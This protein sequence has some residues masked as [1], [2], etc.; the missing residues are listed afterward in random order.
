MNSC[1]DMQVS[2]LSMLSL[3]LF[4]SLSLSLSLSVSLSLSHILVF[5]RK[6]IHTFI[7]LSYFYHHQSNSLF[8]YLSLF[9]PFYQYDKH[10]L[11]NAYRYRKQ[12]WQPHFKTWMRLFAYYFVLIPQ[13]RHESICF[14][15]AMSKQKDRLWFGNQSQKRK[16]EFISSV[17]F[18]KIDLVSHDGRIGLI[19]A[20]LFTLMKKKT[21]TF[22][23]IFN[24]IQDQ[25]WR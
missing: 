9:I 24:F 17:L 4:L 13:E 1:L 6:N 10:T 14:H 12:N 22:F 3:S 8:Q 7:Q 19:N 23:H 18:L 16:T 21:A 2:S 11:C 15:P 5:F 20:Y 25:I